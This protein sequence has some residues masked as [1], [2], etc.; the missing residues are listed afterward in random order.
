MRSYSS[1]PYVC[2]AVSLL[3]WGC[4]SSSGGSEDAGLMDATRDVRV[5]IDA[6]QDSAPQEAGGSHSDAGGCIPKGGPCT[7]IHS[8]CDG[9]GCIVPSG[10]SGLVCF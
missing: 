5:P 2:L 4:G 3:A 8:C 10:D 9:M 7:N 1:T 6:G